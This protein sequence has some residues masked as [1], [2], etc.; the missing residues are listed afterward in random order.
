MRGRGWG[1][2]QVERRGQLLESVAGP[3]HVCLLCPHPANHSTP[4]SRAAVEEKR[5]GVRR[6]ETGW[7]LFGNCDGSTVVCVVG[8]PLLFGCVACCRGPPCQE[9]SC[10]D[11]CVWEGTTMSGNEPCRRVRVGRVY[12]ME[13][14]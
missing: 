7:L 12:R 2:R 13:N 10:V 1:A 3:T 14:S 6:V 9:M 4:R 5:V 11:A 8:R